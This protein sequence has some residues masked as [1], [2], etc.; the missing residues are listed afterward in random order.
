MPS[1]KHHSGP[2]VRQTKV[3]RRQVSAAREQLAAGGLSHEERHRLHSVIRTWDETA[4]QRRLE[5]RHLTIVVAGTLV[6]MAAV[7]VGVGLISAIGAASGQGTAGTFVVSN[8]VCARRT[9]CAIEGTFRSRD[10][11]TVPDVVYAG[12]LPAGAG[13]GTSLP[14]VAPGG[15]SDF[16][17]PP[18]D[19]TRWIYDLLLV[20]V[21]G[22][23]VGFV[24]WASPLGLRKRAVSRAGVV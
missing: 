5:F 7:A 23:A 18:H 15:G 6:A 4:S 9:G 17:Y 16:V 3:S 8:T 24:L 2:P 11:N 12:F 20:V 1:R 10:G 22:S 13:P 19:T 21:V 14:A